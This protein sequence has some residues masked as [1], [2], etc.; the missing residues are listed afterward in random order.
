MKRWTW[1]HQETWLNEASMWVFKKQ[2]MI[3][4]HTKAIKQSHFTCVICNLLD[5]S[6]REG[7][8]LMKSIHSN[9]MLWFCYVIN[10][11]NTNVVDQF[12]SESHHL[13]P[14]NNQVNKYLYYHWFIYCV[15]DNTKNQLDFFTSL[16]FILC[17]W[18]HY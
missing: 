17:F 13:N 5:I 12:D 3:I 15:Q 6:C 7:M 4:C 11:Q 18:S 16:V 1:L 8:L 10:D 2:K 9:I 14:W